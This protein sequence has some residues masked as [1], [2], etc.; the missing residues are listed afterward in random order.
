MVREVGETKTLHENI[1]LSLRCSIYIEL[2]ET[3]EHGSGIH[4]F[5]NQCQLNSAEQPTISVKFRDDIPSG[6]SP[7]TGRCFEVSIKNLTP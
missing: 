6:T 3:I 1:C 7:V 5:F 4:D 2:S